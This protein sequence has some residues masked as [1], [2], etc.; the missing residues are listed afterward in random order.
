MHTD[1]ERIDVQVLEF[2][3]ATATVQTACLR[4]IDAVP[5]TVEAALKGEGAPRIL[6]A[7]DG[8]VREACFRILAAFDA[9]GLDPPRGSPIVNFAPAA[10]RKTG[11]GFDLPMALALAGAA[12]MFPPARLQRVAAFGEVSLQGLVLPCCGALPVA[13]ALAA[14]G[15]ETLLVSPQDAPLAALAPG[16]R[17][18]APRTLHDALRWL[19]EELVLPCVATAPAVQAAAPEAPDLADLRGLETPKLAL[20]VAAAG[21]HNLL[22]VGPPGSGKSALLRRLP[23]LLP[24]PSDAESFEILRIRSASGQ[25]PAAPFPRPFRA[26]HHTSSYAALL[27]G[28]SGEPH[29]GEVTLAHHGVLF[30][31]ELPEFRREVLEGLRQPLEDGVVTIGRTREVVTLPAGFQLVAAMNP[32]PCGWRGHPTRPCL[33]GPLQRQRYT[34]R[35]S[36]PL[37]DR[38]DLQLEVASVDPG[39]LRAAP[40]PAWSTAAQR[41]RV[42]AA[43]EMQR[44]RNRHGLRSLPNARLPDALL[45]RVAALEDAAEDALEA[46]LRRSRASARTR[47]RLL[48]VARTLADLEQREHVGEEHVLLAVRLR[49]GAQAWDAGPR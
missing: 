18:L 33:C 15:C 36:G 22:L 1:P 48:R 25:L 11:A 4:G 5:V 14:S 23:G 29:P 32:C 41:E 10:L 9:L 16:L 12:G 21:R 17:V 8:T 30:L 40:D 31:D 19:A 39:R 38:I 37:L 6:G 46:A 28:G 2:R 27:G 35:L 43:D 26:P 7:T 20:A 42:L 34:S 44:R 13:L 24:P 45:R 3:G 47:V 49:H